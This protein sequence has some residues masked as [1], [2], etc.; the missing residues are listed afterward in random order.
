MSLEP[1]SRMLLMT[2]MTNN[3]FA[4]PTDHAE[5]LLRKRKKKMVAGRMFAC[6]FEKLWIE[7]SFNFFYFM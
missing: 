4:E 7:F 1:V 2:T 3:F 6:D 5:C